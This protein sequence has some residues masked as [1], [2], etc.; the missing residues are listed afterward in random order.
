ML[1]RHI[2]RLS[3]AAIA[4]IV[5]NIVVCAAYTAS[6]NVGV[7]T[8]STNNNVLVT[9]CVVYVFLAVV[10]LFSPLSGFLADV[11]CGRY[12]VIFA[13]IGLTFCAFLIDSVCAIIMTLVYSPDFGSKYR[14]H[15]VLLLV[16]PVVLAF[17]M[18]V[19]GLGC[20]QANFIQFGLDQLL[21]A[22]SAS[23]ALFIHLV[24]WAGNLGALVI[25]VFIEVLWC[26]YGIRSRYGALC[27]LSI[28][29]DVAFLSDH[30]ML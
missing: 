9:M 1:P 25:Q 5:I 29:T 16:I 6:L 17:M 21:D 15:L 24:M 30:F 28:S 22:P 7:V 11:C 8:V 20:Y 3:K 18:F 13:G 10:T 4:V 23:L 12:K 26:K 27:G 2:C 19:T 14:S